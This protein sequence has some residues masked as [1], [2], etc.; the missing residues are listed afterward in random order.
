[1]RSRLLME[2]FEALIVMWTPL[3]WCRQSSTLLMLQVSELPAQIFPK[4]PWPCLPLLW[5]HLRWPPP[6]RHMPS[7]TR[8]LMPLL[9]SSLRISLCTTLLLPLLLQ[10]LHLWSL[11]RSQ[12]PLLHLSLPSRF[13]MLLLLWLLLWQLQLWQ[14]LLLSMLQHLKDLNTTVRM[15]LAST[16]MA[17]VT[18]TLSG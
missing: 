3:V 4:A 10:C 18:P 17:T 5:T 8:R 16:A 6:S 13:T 7:P 14:L 11:P 12:L 15:T 1:M 2:L 9:L